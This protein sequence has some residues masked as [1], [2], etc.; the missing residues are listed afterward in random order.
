MTPGA[1]GFSKHPRDW[2]HTHC[3]VCTRLCL[4]LLRIAL[5]HPHSPVLLTSQHHLAT[6][7]RSSTVHTMHLP[8]RQTQH[9]AV[10]YLLLHLA[11]RVVANPASCLW[12]N[13][14]TMPMP[15]ALRHNKMNLCGTPCAACC[16][17]LHQSIDFMPCRERWLSG[18]LPPYPGQLWHGMRVRWASSS[19]E[20]GWLSL[21][22]FNT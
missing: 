14:P 4:S 7:N 5:P 8:G 9:S 10:Q 2:A 6:R 17:C 3:A 20:W 13:N 12:V 16:N 11:W 15:A 19:S 21:S 22:A 1:A 18:R